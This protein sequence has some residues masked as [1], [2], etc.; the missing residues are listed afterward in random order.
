MSAAKVRKKPLTKRCQKGYPCKTT[1]INREKNCRNPLKWQAKDLAGW[2]KLQEERLAVTNQKRSRAGLTPATMND[3][4]YIT[5]DRTKRSGS[6]KSVEQK[7]KQPPAEIVEGMNQ[8]L[9]PLQ[10]FNR[11]VES[12]RQ[13]AKVGGGGSDRYI[14]DLGDK[15]LG[16]MNQFEGYRKTW[17]KTYSLG[18]KNGFDMSAFNLP[19]TV[20]L[21]RSEAK[22]L[23]ERWGVLLDNAGKEKAIA[24]KGS[25]T[26]SEFDPREELE[27]LT[28]LTAKLAKERDPKTHE[29]SEEYYS[30]LRE[31]Q[32]V[33][34][35]VE[36]LNEERSRSRRNSP[37]FKK[38]QEDAEQE[39]AREW[40]RLYGP[41]HS[42]TTYERIVNRIGRQ[43]SMLTDNR[44]GYW[45]DLTSPSAEA[46]KPTV[47]KMFA[48]AVKGGV[49]QAVG[50]KGDDYQ[51]T[52]R[53]KEGIAKPHI[54][55]RNLATGEVKKVPMTQNAFRDYLSHLDDV[56]HANARLVDGFSD[57]PTAN[58]KPKE[59][60]RPA[61]SKPENSDRPVELDQDERVKNLK[62][63]PSTKDVIQS[64]INRGISRSVFD[65]IIRHSAGNYEGGGSQIS[66]DLS[67]NSSRLNKKTI[68]ELTSALNPYMASIPPIIK[69]DG[70]TLS[71][72]Y[73]NPDTSYSNAMDKMKDVRDRLE[74]MGVNVAHLHDIKSDSVVSKNSDRPVESKPENSDRPVETQTETTIDP[75]YT[76]PLKGA[77]KIAVAR[78]WNRR[79]DQQ[80]LEMKKL[81]KERQVEFIEENI[82]TGKE[83]PVVRYPLTYGDN[84]GI[85]KR[86]RGDWDVVD[87]T[88]K[89][90]IDSHPTKLDAQRFIASLLGEIGDK[91]LQQM[92]ASERRVLS[93]ISEGITGLAK[94]RKSHGNPN[95][96][97]VEVPPFI[98]QQMGENVP[99][100][101]ISVKGTNTPAS[102]RPV[103]NG[104]KSFK[105][106]RYGHQLFAVV[107]SSDLTP[108]QKQEFAAKAKSLNG[109]YS[110][111]D[112]DGAI[113]GYLFRDK[114]KAE[115]FQDWMNGKSSPPSPGVS[116]QPTEV[117][118]VA[119]GDRASVIPEP[120][121]EK[122]S[123][124]MD[125][126]RADKMAELKDHYESSS[127]IPQFR[128]G[129]SG[130]YAAVGSDN[131]TYGKQYETE[132]DGINAVKE[133]RRK[134]A[135]D[136]V[137]AMRYKS[138]AEIDRQIEYWRKE[139]GIETMPV[140][141]PDANTT[142]QPTAKEFGD[143]LNVTAED[144]K[145]NALYL[146]VAPD[147]GGYSYSDRD[148]EWIKSKYGDVNYGDEYRI[149]KEGD[150]I[151]IEKRSIVYKKDG[152]PIS[153]RLSE[154]DWKSWY[155]KQNISWNQESLVSKIAN[156]N[157]TEKPHPLVTNANADK[158]KRR[159]QKEKEEKERQIKAEQQQAELTVWTAIKKEMAKALP[160]PKQKQS[161]TW[162][163][164]DGKDRNGIADL[165][166][167]N[168]AIT[169]LVGSRG[170][171]RFFVADVSSGFRAYKGGLTATEAKELLGILW[172]ERGDKPIMKGESLDI[173]DD[174]RE[175]VRNHGD[176]D[177]IPKLYSQAVTDR[178]NAG[179]EQKAQALQSNLFGGLDEIPVD[180][181][182]EAAIA[183]KADQE[184]TDKLNKPDKR[185]APPK[186]KKSNLSDRELQ[187]RIEESN[188]YYLAIGKGAKN[189]RRP[190]WMDGNSGGGGSK[191]KTGVLQSFVAEQ[192]FKLG[193]FDF[194]SR[195]DYD[196]E[197]P[198]VTIRTPGGGQYQIYK[199]KEAL[200]TFLG[201]IG[202]SPKKGESLF[203]SLKRNSEKV[204]NFSELTISP[205]DRHLLLL[206]A[207]AANRILE[208]P[209]F[210]R[211]GIL[212]RL[213]G[214]LA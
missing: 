42:T 90:T 34:K 31:L 134:R 113:A 177:A 77:D 28:R 88:S 57:Q 23:N 69:A 135:E 165:Y 125:M 48:H 5:A 192:L 159:I 105:H 16:L 145:G 181:K 94:L 17:E 24:D 127:P 67:V 190:S 26:P 44:G 109:R 46:M 85:V 157:I 151:A 75:K 65:S 200:S 6:V 171:G 22:A 183:Q 95:R 76:K 180:E 35:I 13:T 53:K 66:V 206:A 49:I 116:R 202:L 186:P 176:S 56:S 12:A 195:V 188:D 204:Q 40:K 60:D 51:F 27:R 121:K 112:K 55:L 110:P 108:K 164:E 144:F 124:P 92:K 100:L 73:R 64:L 103:E 97:R 93:G 98:R 118:P 205:R 80:F 18:V 96:V 38:A 14:W 142:Y 168:Y 203:E 37:E 1:C 32:R 198:M 107:P 52:Y 106:T 173:S 160:K 193:A 149:V 33:R 214:Q 79:I 20:P 62:I 41:M 63:L 122:R 70:D 208:H 178:L 78:D 117:K 87:L 174:L 84:W 129:L 163:G 115:Q 150:S 147:S 137:E 99:S 36:S 45:G 199:T 111:Y 182:R 120:P 152:D 4:G 179:K 132:S 123:H 194:P 153:D 54:E 114:K 197:P 143:R 211:Q 19:T 185:K 187:E 25:E 170:N 158:E 172:K 58:P 191:K 82:R 189:V 119:G 89:R 138:D 126:S 128:K 21:T 133:A 169:Q 91:P 59:G 72:I 213:G 166:G 201:A 155:G 140:T 136:S 29:A 39:S 61:E 15:L 71:I 184:F 146:G 86:E 131:S 104:I 10:E 139:R 102:D 154:G 9:A 209:E 50:S 161:I 212:N 196:K 210:L 47:A 175:I 148:K 156:F 207:T 81:E 7:G 162:K 167:D 74:A 11:L 141:K 30:A 68:N 43:P 8:L 3:Q 2:L 130:K 83:E 101:P